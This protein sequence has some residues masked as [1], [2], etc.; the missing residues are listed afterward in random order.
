MAY[1]GTSTGGIGGTDTVLNM[2]ANTTYFG[3]TDYDADGTLDILIRDAQG[4]LVVDSGAGNG[5]F[6]HKNPNTIAVGW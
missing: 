4:N 1:Q 2:C 3:M 5:W 6:Q